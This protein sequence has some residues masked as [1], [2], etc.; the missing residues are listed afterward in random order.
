MVR[1]PLPIDSLLPAILANLRDSPN[2]IIEAAPGAGKTTRVPPSLLD[3][4]LLEGRE[5]LV[6][7]PRRLATR[8]AA[9]RV[10]EERGELPV[11]HRY[12][13]RFE[14]VPVADEIAVRD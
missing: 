2:L 6:L 12:T 13:V 1:Q 3:A 10:A 9:S 14:D 5:I 4:G 7:E 11:K 8:L